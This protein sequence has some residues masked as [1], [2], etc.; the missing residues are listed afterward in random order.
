MKNFYNKRKKTNRGKNFIH[1]IVVTLSLPQMKIAQMKIRFHRFRN[2]LISV[3][4]FCFPSEDK[5]PGLLLNLHTRGHVQISILNINS[6]KASVS[7]I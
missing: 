4:I 6:L 2:V 3:T 5:F 7:L 1:R